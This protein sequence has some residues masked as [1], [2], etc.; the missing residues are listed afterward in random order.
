MINSNSLNRMVKEVLLGELTTKQRPGRRKQL[1][2]GE[3][4]LRAFKAEE[5]ENARALRLKLYCMFRSYPGDTG[6]T[7]QARGRGADINRGDQKH[8]T[9]DM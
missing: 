6:M 1:G 9:Q 5:T 4:W 7:N 2:G 8:I 3:G